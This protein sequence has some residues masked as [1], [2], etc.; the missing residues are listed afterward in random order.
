MSMVE[1]IARHQRHALELRKLAALMSLRQ[2]RATLI[3]AAVEYEQLAASLQ[4]TEFRA[5]L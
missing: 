5:S 2:A 3:Q 4:E 1:N